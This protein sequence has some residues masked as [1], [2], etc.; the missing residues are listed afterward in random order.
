MK[1]S[2]YDFASLATALAVP[3]ATLAYVGYISN[4][5]TRAENTIHDHITGRWHLRVVHIDNAFAPDLYTFEERYGCRIFD[6]ETFFRME[7]AKEMFDTKVS[8]RD[9][10]SLKKIQQ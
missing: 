1:N 6:R 4:P 2:F 7:G 5:Y 10:Q 9:S 8:L 3:L